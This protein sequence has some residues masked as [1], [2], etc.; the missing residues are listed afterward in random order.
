MDAQ[1]ILFDRIEAYLSGV[2]DPT[3]KQQFESEL[4]TDEMLQREVD[5]H[6]KANLAIRHGYNMSLKERLKSI[7]REMQPARTRR[8]IPISVR[9][10]AAAASVLLVLAI[11]AHFYAHQ[12]YSTDAVADKMFAATQPEVFRGREDYVVTLGERF[13]NAEQLFRDGRYEEARQQYLVIIKEDS[14]LKD[15]A[16]WNLAMCLFAL[17]PTSDQFGIVF[18]RLLSDTNHDY[19][20]RALELRKIM[21]SSL[22]KLVN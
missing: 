21:D 13:A 22:Y 7:D 18:D 19:H 14:L 16:E 4:R 3:Q 17:D 20:Q 2:L 15:Q 8:I 6:R 1:E 9:R 11:G 10:I 5:R 12:T